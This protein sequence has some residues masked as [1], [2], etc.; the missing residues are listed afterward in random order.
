MDLRK[1]KKLIELVEE[2]GIREI[3]VKSGDEAVRIS[4]GSHQSVSELALDRAEPVKNTVT[5]K[6]HDHSMPIAS[7]KAPMAGTFYR[8]PSPGSDSFVEV[9]DTVEVGQ[10]VCIIESMK[11]MHEIKSTEHG[12]VVSFEAADGQPINTEDELIRLS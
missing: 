7:I 12:K 6:P 10:V 2:S 11:M 1:V 3:E 9:G 8:A 4:M 5:E